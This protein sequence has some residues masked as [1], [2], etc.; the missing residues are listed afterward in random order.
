MVVYVRSAVSPTRKIVGYVDD[1]SVVRKGTGDP[2]PGR[3]AGSIGENGEVYQRQGPEMDE[4]Y[5]GYVTEDG[6]ICK[7]TPAYGDSYQAGFVQGKKVYR[8][9][10]DAPG[11]LV[12]YIE[13]E[14]STHMIGA[15]ALILGLLDDVIVCPS[16]KKEGFI[17]Q[18]GLKWLCKS[19][20]ASGT[21]S[22]K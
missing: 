6:D 18:K 16:C 17:V 20:G 3:L 10:F 19:C 2:L 12:A 1:V 4:F 5:I 11:P 8:G 22:K 21:L 13:G 9:T 15:A 7:D 14:A